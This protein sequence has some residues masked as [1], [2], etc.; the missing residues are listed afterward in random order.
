[1]QGAF[2][3]LWIAAPLAL[4]VLAILSFVQFR[5]AGLAL[6]TVAAPLPAIAAA[7]QLGV[8]P[9]P[10]SYLFG[11]LAGAV[12]AAGIEIDVC[13][14]D[15]AS[16]AAREA[17]RR[18]LPLL[19]WPSIVAIALSA[20]TANTAVLKSVAVTCGSILSSATI[21]LCIGR[22]LPYGENFITRLN[23]VREVR[24]RLLDTLTFTVQPRWG[25]SV[26]GIGLVF[27]TLG[28]FGSGAPSAQAL[29]LFGVVEAV[30][31]VAAAIAT[32]SIR[33]TLGL[34]L[35]AVILICTSTWLPVAALPILALAIAPAL[36]MAMQ[37]ARFARE[38][39]RYAVATLRSF[40][41][42]A[43]TIVFFAIGGA[44]TFWIF[45]R[46]G[47]A[48]L[49]LTSAPLALLIFPALVTMLYDLLPPRA[50]PDAYR[51]R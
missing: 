4:S 45:E 30:F 43:A 21:V 18:S 32:R 39:D 42:Q 36:V 27:A 35:T 20:L 25:W 13:D 10:V 7:M 44:F 24:E 38:G 48:I 47:A 9:D 46:S 12:L 11:L 33:R 22:S 15:T 51:I 34:A 8:A 16:D 19:L 41:R 17:L 40:E 1:V 29:V 3:P 26:S 14:G 6:L 49:I 31:G 5:H 50:S 23:R 2:L 37:S 28:Y